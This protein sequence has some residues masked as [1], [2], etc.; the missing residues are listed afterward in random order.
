[1]L[2]YNNNTDRC[3]FKRIGDISD[4]PTLKHTKFYSGVVIKYA[5]I[6]CTG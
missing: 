3:I 5:I 4:E 6:I 1:M 2:I